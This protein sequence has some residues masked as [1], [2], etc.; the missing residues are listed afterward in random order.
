MADH[1]N[2]FVSF[3][4]DERK[5]RFCI[6]IDLL[7]MELNRHFLMNI[8]APSIFSLLTPT[9]LCAPL[10]NIILLSVSFSSD[11]IILSIP[12]G[13]RMLPFCCIGQRAGLRGH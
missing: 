9:I 1:N 3:C 8:N 12:K 10:Q 5:T 2:D 11:I 6:I 13:L 7:F 4:N